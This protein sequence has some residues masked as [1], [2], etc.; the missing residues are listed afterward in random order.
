MQTVSILDGGMGQELLKRS[1]LP[2]TPLW[3][4]QIL[5]DEPDVVEGVHRDYVAA[6]AQIITTC[7]YTVTPT[8]L[9]RAGIEEQFHALQEQ[10]CLLACKV[11]DDCA[12][13]IEGPLAVAGS[14]PPL[15]ASYRADKVPPKDE[16]VK[17]YRRL[18]EVQKDHVD[19][20]IC[21]TMSSVVEFEAACTAALESGKPVYGSVTLSDDHPDQLRSGETLDL[22]I[23]AAQYLDIDMFCVNCCWPE[24]INH[25]VDMLSQSGLKFGLYANGFTDVKALEPGG[26]VDVLHARKDLDPETYGQFALGWAKAGA[27][28]IGGCCEVG[29]DHIRTL[30]SVLS[31]EGY[32]LPRTGGKG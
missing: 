9:A 7:N 5:I 16:A 25:N 29:P 14:L 1:Q 26:T 11:R 18:V 17:D 4:T 23:Q 15:V 28:M 22:A 6:G 20:F 13:E 10:A 32:V 31:A 19:L 8:R 30:N 3:S 12:Q 2:P 21:E 24:T 27:S